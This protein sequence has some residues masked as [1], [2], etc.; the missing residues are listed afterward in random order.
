NGTDQKDGSSVG[1]I[2]A[3]ARPKHEALTLAVLN[4]GF[5]IPPGDPN[6]RVDAWFPFR[7]EG[8]ILGF[9]PHMH[10]RGKDFRYEAIRPDGKTEVLLSVPRFDFNWQ[11]T[12]RLAQAYA[13]PRG[14]RLHCVAH[15]DNS[16]QNPNNPDP[17]QEVT[18]GD[19]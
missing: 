19:Q 5:K 6:Y 2:F 17:T 13:M 15:F 3:K 18:W 14:S 1:L 11:S 8:H 16:A 7:K 4:P 12:Y 9:M 10:L